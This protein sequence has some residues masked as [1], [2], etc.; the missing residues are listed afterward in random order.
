M[1]VSTITPKYK[2][3]KPVKTDPGK[4][5]L[6]LYNKPLTIEQLEKYILKPASKDLVA[7]DIET[8]G[9]S[10]FY[11]HTYTSGSGKAKVQEEYHPTIVGIGLAWPARGSYKAAYFDPRKQS[12]ETLKHFYKRL[13]DL[14]LVAHNAMFDGLWLRHEGLRLGVDVRPNWIADTYGYLKQFAAQDF[15]G[16]GHGLKNA[17]VDLLGWDET[18]DIEQK[19]W[20]IEHGYIKGSI[21]KEIKEKLGL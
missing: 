13:G 10:P 8:R 15:L 16:Q 6:R 19:K 5:N 21:P 12:P 20:L 4:D 14:A 9:L 3:L 18:N 1:Q 7:I 2:L 17:Q 11:P